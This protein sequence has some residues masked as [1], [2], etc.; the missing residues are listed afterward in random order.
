MGKNLPFRGWSR[1]YLTSPCFA[2]YN[3][4]FQSLYLRA[5][6]LCL[7]FGPNVDKEG[8]ADLCNAP[9]LTLSRW[10]TSCC[11]LPALRPDLLLKKCDVLFFRRM[12]CFFGFVLMVIELCMITAGNVSWWEAKGEYGS[13]LV[14]IYMPRKNAELTHAGL[15]FYMA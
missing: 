9:H 4:T 15:R 11:D 10:F 3:T 2:R 13:K 14:M 5:I 8:L 12:V 1:A 6:C 7:H